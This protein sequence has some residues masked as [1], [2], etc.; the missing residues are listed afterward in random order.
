MPTLVFR[1]E[2]VATAAFPLLNCYEIA[3]FASRRIFCAALVSHVIGERIPIRFK[4]LKN[5]AACW[6]EDGIANVDF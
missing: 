3:L 4:N 5:Y 6:L 2:K 1:N